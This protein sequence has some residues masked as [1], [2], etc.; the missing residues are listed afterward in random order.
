MESSMNICGRL[1]MHSFELT[2]V[3]RWVLTAT[4]A[5]TGIVSARNF[6]RTGAKICYQHNIQKLSDS[7]AF[8]YTNTVERREIAVRT[9]NIGH[10]KKNYKVQ[11]ELAP[12][13][14]S[15]RSRDKFRGEQ[16]HLGGAVSK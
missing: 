6:V 4:A 7:S 9:E 12:E 16:E 8:G 15:D 2:A 3:I 11:V 10:P 13:N 14:G 1:E 5:I